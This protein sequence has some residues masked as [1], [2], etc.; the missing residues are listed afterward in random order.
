L[1]D[2]AEQLTRMTGRPVL[3]RT[4]IEGVFTYEFFFAPERWRY[5]RRNPNETRPH[6]MSPSLFQVLDQ[7]LGLRL[8]EARRAVE[9]LT[10]DRVERPTEN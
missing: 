10:I 4:G 5:W 8:E 9:V 2:L 1:T 3:N 7:E 6:L